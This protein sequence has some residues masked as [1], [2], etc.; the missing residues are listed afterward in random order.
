MQATC[1][2]GLSRTLLGDRLGLGSMSNSIIAPPDLAGL[3]GAFDNDLGDPDTA[4]AGAENIAAITDDASLDD[5]L[6]CGKSLHPPPWCCWQMARH[7]PSASSNLATRS[8]P[9][10][11]TPAKHPRTRRRRPRP[12]RHRPLTTSPSRVATGQPLSTP[13]ATTSSGTS[14]RH[15]WVDA[16]ALKNGDHLRTPDSTTATVVTGHTPADTTGQMWDLSVPGGGDH[17]FYIDVIHTAV[18]VHNCTS[19]NQ[20]Q[21]QVLRGQAPNGIERVDTANPGT[22]DAQPHIHFSDWRSTLNRDGTWGHG[23]G[24]DANLTSNMINWILSNGWGI[25][26]E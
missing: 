24:S 25:P 3:V 12:P 2:P 9:P 8:W 22:D 15:R 4:H 19:P 11:P 6:D 26:G 23:D 7:V 5:Q 20:M 1:G 17:D 18:L 21:Q 14:S 16:H 13:S 10:T